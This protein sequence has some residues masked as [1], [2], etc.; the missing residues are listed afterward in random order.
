MSSCRVY[1]SVTPVTAFCSKALARPCSADLSSESRSS[2]TC[3]SVSLM[4]IPSGTLVDSDPLGPVTSTIPSFVL[5]LTPFGM[6]IGFLPILDISHPHQARTLKLKG[7]NT[8]VISV[9][10]HSLQCHAS[11]KYNHHLS[12]AQ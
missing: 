7:R 1:P 10:S 8:P 3:A 5:T 12:T 6:V 4:V 2:V 9:N 11:F